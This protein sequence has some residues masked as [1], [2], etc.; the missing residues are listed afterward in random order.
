MIAARDD[1]RPEP[2]GF[3][4]GRFAIRGPGGGMRISYKVLLVGGIPILIAAAIAL[5]ALLLLDASDRA[6]NGAVLASTIYRNLLVAVSV[7]NDYVDS[8][9]SER[10]RHMERFWQLATAAHVDL[11]DLSEVVGDS[12][13]QQATARATAALD[14]YLVLM[15]DL[16]DATDNNDVLVAEMASRAALLISLTD[17]ARERQHASNADIVATLAERDRQ[18][19]N[20]RD[21]VD[22]AQEL[23]AAVA[24]VDLDL[25]VLAAPERPGESQSDRRLDL[26][27][28]QSLLRNSATDLAALLRAQG[29]E[30]QAEDLDRLSAEYQAAAGAV[31]GVAF[32][33]VPALPLPGGDLATWIERLVK[34]NGTAQR[35]LHEE[36]A[37]LLTYSVQ[38]HETE[39]ATQNIAIATL[40]LSGAAEAALASRDVPAAAAVLDQSRN[41]GSTV[42]ELPISPLIQTEMIGAI[43]QW[44]RGLATTSDRLRRQNVM[45]ADMDAAAGTMIDGARS[46]N[47]M[48]TGNADSLGRFIR[49]ILILGAAIGLF[50]GGGVALVVARSITRPLK[51]LKED[52]VGLA[53]DPGAGS[54][55]AADR[56]D[57]LGDMARATNFF[58]TEIAQREQALRRAKDRADDALVEL[59][60]TQANL[61]QAEKLASLG[62]LVAGVAHEINT[63][64]G[65]ALTTSTLMSDEVV[66]FNEV[67]ATRQ[68]Q[69]SVFDRFVARM[70]E[71]SALLLAN[72]TRAA[73]LIHS[74]K[75]VAA[76]Q[77]SG[78]RRHFELKAWLDDLL[79]S[80]VPVVRKSGHQV[81][82]TCPA[83]LTLDSYPGA[84]GQVLTNLL[85]N[86][87]THA[88]PDGVAGRIAVDVAAAGDT[89]RITFRDDGRGIAPENLGKVFD[90]FFTT[91]RR[92]GN[93]GLGLHIAYNLVTGLL[94]GAIAV[95]SRPGEGT[96]FVIDLPADVPA[97]TE[98]GRTT[99][100]LE[101]ASS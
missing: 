75:Q 18:L 99:H 90:P 4:P 49:N 45:I 87:V 76:D 47:D 67:A 77:A 36:V 60:R 98:Q 83:G 37:E 21:I 68:V 14:R 31:A 96:R 46:L 88:Y 59:Q 19:R 71:G 58:V 97:R 5:V 95:D 81:T 29:Q 89:V 43:G 17:Q 85:V 86:A 64:L 74:F 41:L 56:G 42:S 93:T 3:R 16:I 25:A 20:A 69:R 53:A 39:Q 1:A 26:S 50:V 79:N 32:A 92:A 52:M 7:R 12:R 35:A 6:R 94:Q 82:A 28:N 40:K 33:D 101:S 11:E 100:V 54:L 2:D 72:L 22:R 13:H 48:L 73:N 27:F 65:V 10:T 62:Q 80:L 51:R 66:R 44:Q 70:T 15:G 61:V 91:G 57:E 84:L 63:P 8:R 9:P 24:A 23:R 34:V 78:E 38:A 55:A 30:R